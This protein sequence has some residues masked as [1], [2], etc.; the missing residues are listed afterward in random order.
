MAAAVAS[1]RRVVSGGWH[2]WNHLQ[3]VS[4]QTTDHAAGGWLPGCTAERQA[5]AERLIVNLPEAGGA[6]AGRSKPGGQSFPRGSARRFDGPLVRGFLKEGLRA[7][8]LRD[9]LLVLRRL[10]RLG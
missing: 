7:V 5:A 9:V 2:G 6:R 1:E 10:E 4:E 8:G 3:S